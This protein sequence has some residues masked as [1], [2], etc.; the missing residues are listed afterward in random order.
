MNT[1]KA[2]I[3]SSKYDSDYVPKEIY[4]HISEF[5][6]KV[7]MVASS[8]YHTIILTK[9]GTVFACGNNQEGQLGLDDYKDRNT[10]TEVTLPDDKVASQVVAGS[11]HTMIIAKDGTVLACGKNDEGQL[12]LGDYDNR[13]T[14]TVVPDLPDGK[15]ASQVVAGGAQTM[16]IAKD[17]TVFACG[18]NGIGQLGLGD[19]ENKNTF[20]QVPALPNEGRDRNANDDDRGE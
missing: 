9:D 7:K 3:A 2:L 16:I 10:F 4:N 19:T 13:D 18:N 12:G 8:A 1:L 11:M 14:F 20:T 15:V 17:D 6:F 5:L